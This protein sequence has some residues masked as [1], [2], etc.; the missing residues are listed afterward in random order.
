MLYKADKQYESQLF[1]IL[2]HQEAETKVSSFFLEII[3]FM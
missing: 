3:A 2:S 1:N